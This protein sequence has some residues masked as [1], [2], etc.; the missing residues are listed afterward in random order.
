MPSPAGGVHL[1]NLGAQRR[2]RIEISSPAARTLPWKLAGN[3]DVTGGQDP[4][5]VP[6]KPSPRPTARSRA[7]IEVSSPAARTLPSVRDPDQ[8]NRDVPTLAQLPDPGAQRR[9]RI[10]FLEL[11]RTAVR[12]IDNAGP[13]PSAERGSKGARRQRGHCRRLETPEH[14]N[15]RR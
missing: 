2:A 14:N 6:A 5:T 11:D 1:I 3:Q 15:T 10:E 13:G 8:T 7:R 9:T 12:N 4:K